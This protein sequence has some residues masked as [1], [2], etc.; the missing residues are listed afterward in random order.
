MM[1][2]DGNRKIRLIPLYGQLYTLF[3]SY[4]DDDRLSILLIF[5][6]YIT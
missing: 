2:I 3:L 1:S 4:Y 5:I 6:F